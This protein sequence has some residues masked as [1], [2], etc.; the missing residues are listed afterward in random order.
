MT[1]SINTFGFPKNLNLTIINNSSKL[2]SYEQ[3]NLSILIFARYK[4][5]F[6]VKQ[7]PNDEFINKL[8]EWLV[9][10]VMDFRDIDIAFTAYNNTKDG[11]P[12]KDDLFRIVKP[13]EE[14]ALYLSKVAELNNKIMN[15]KINNDDVLLIKAFTLNLLSY[16]FNRLL[17]KEFKRQTIYFNEIINFDFESEIHKIN[18]EFIFSINKEEPNKK[19]Q[20][21]LMYDSSFEVADFLS[22]FVFKIA[23]I[24]L[25]AV[26]R[27]QGHTKK[28]KR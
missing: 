25:R 6:F 11:T 9:N 26:R 15:E 3:K 21:N 12:L 20:I 7:N 24:P 17:N 8:Y 23:S 5:A 10:N 28:K 13:L 2:S 18:K 22:T 14:L 19:E 16:W 4:L 27:N 1:S